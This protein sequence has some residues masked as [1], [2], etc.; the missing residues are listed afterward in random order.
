MLLYVDDIIV[1]G[2]NSSLIDSFTRKLHSEF[3]TKDLGSLSYF[4]DLEASHTPN[5]LF[6]SQLK[7]ARDILTRAQ[8]LDSKPVH[9]PT[10]VSSH[11]TADGSPFSDPTLYRC[12]DLKFST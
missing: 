5:G 4:L 3:A 12:N 9:T 1:T 2:N 11:L 6:I 8:L 7:Y 10:V